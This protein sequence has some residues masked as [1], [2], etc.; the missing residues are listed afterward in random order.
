MARAVLWADRHEPLISVTQHL[1]THIVT[2]VGC[3]HSKEEPFNGRVKEAHSLADLERKTADGDSL[4]LAMT[5]GFESSIREV[6]VWLAEKSMMAVQQAEGQ[7]LA[8][9]VKF[10]HCIAAL[11]VIC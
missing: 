9:A 4:T 2:G 1:P 7:C 6:H 8:C 10:G 5:W 3:T 11:V